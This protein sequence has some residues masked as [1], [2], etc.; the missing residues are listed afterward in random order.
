MARSA[1]V[2][3]AVPAVWDPQRG[4]LGAGALLTLNTSPN[5]DKYFVP[6]RDRF[7]LIRTGF[8]FG[9][10]KSGTVYRIGPHLS[11]PSLMRFD[12][13]WLAARGEGPSSTSPPRADPA[14]RR[15]RRT[16]AAPRVQ[17]KYSTMS[18]DPHM[19]GLGVPI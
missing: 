4:Q 16:H 1:E 13:H 19:S 17:H 12:A 15:T 2:A 6:N 18:H 8:K 14:P 5:R 3:D 9:R 7:F 11:L 10:S